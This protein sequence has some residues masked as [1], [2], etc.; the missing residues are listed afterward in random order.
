LFGWAAEGMR[1]Y[2]PHASARNH[3]ARPTYV[4]CQPWMGVAPAKSCWQMGTGRQ[5]RAVAMLTVAVARQT[6][7]R[8]RAWLVVA[9]GQVPRLHLQDPQ[10]VWGV[11]KGG[12]AAPSQGPG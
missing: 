7:G 12:G 5:G 6:A 2:E 9:V 8:Q 10:R 1:T 3:T 4:P 11:E